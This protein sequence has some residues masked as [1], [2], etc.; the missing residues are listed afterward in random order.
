[1]RREAL[2]DIYMLSA[3]NTA[4]S[5]AASSMFAVI[6]RL[7][8][9]GKRH[10]PPLAVGVSWTDRA[11][12][13]SGELATGYLR[14]MR[15]GTARLT[16]GS[17]RLR[18]ALSRFL[19]RALRPSDRYALRVDERT[20]I[21]L[22]D[23]AM[24]LREATKWAANVPPSGNDC[25]CDPLVAPRAADDGACDAVELINA[26]V[27]YHDGV[28]MNFPA[29]GACWRRARMLPGRTRHAAFTNAEASGEVAATAREN[30]M[31]LL[32]KV[33]QE[34][35]HYVASA[36]AQPIRGGAKQTEWCT[37]RRPTDQEPD[38]ATLRLHIEGWRGIAHSY[39]VAAA[40][41]LAELAPRCA[42]ELSWSDAPQ[43]L[44]I[45]SAT[46]SEVPPLPP[47][48]RWLPFGTVPEYSTVLRLSWPY[49]LSAPTALHTKAIVFAT[50]EHLWCPD[51]GSRMRGSPL[52]PNAPKSVS[53]LTPSLWSFEGL[54]ACGVDRNRI[55]IAPHGVP[56]IFAHAKTGYHPRRS[57]VRDAYQWSGRFVFLHVGAATPNKNLHTLLRA[58]AAVVRRYETSK[59][60]RRPLLVLK[61]LDT[62]YNSY[63]ATE[64]ELLAAFADGPPKWRQYVQTIGDEYTRERLAELYFGSDVY[65][66]ASMAEAF[67]MPLA[68]AMTAGLPI[69]AP[70]G[71]ATEEVV[72]PSTAVLVPS[73]VT[74]REKR[75]GA[76]IVVDGQFFA[77]ALE[78]LLN[79]SSEHSKRAQKYGTRLARKQYSIER[80]A[81]LVLA[82]VMMR[83]PEPGIR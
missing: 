77:G 81:D 46:A 16:D 74:P 33:E 83:N 36:D 75:N 58:Y 10:A 7:W 76:L 2:F 47:R 18:A 4:L 66:T 12:I 57:E 73:V 48:V 79:N 56:A 26:G 55:G 3:A 82:E 1:M 63:Q 9:V 53:F 80:S 70:A 67:Q 24:V 17:E 45:G 6:A 61:G 52:W 27:E 71:G 60:S 65:V 31:V 44:H 8:G 20:A 28:L 22:V 30:L 35:H 51:P 72:N 38:R 37:N 13:V 39:A 43:P 21:P 25:V 40:D 68:E 78:E 59:S 42:I 23:V 15:N 69:I 29:A 62:L 19:G 34:Y 49:N 54:V 64:A 50:A 14:G 5:G 11:G 41:L 32:S